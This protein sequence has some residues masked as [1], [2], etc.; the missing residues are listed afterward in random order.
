VLSLMLLVAACTVVG[1]LAMMV[2]EKRR[3][4]GI[5]RTMGATEG[6]VR[7]IFLWEALFVGG[8]SG[9]IGVTVGG[10]FGWLQQQYG[11]LALEGGEN[12]L[13]NAYPIEMRATDFVAVMATV[14]VLAW[15]AAYY[16]ART[17]ARNTISACLVP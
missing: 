8:L 12:F 17:A 2:V 10:T 4:I 9:L 15:L 5:L 13:V 14:L 16:P 3:E 7:R 1:T 11:I 6:F